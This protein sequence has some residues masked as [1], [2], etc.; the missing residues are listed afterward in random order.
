MNQKEIGIREVPN[1]GKWLT[2]SF[3]HLFAMFGATI[4]VPFLVGLSPAVALVSSGLGTLAYLLIT[5][6]QIPAYLGSSFAFIAPIVLAKSLGGME[7]VMVGSFLAG[8]VYGGVALMIRGLG[9]KWLLQIL[10]PIVVGVI[11]VI[12]LG[13][14][15]T[16]VDMAMY[17]PG[18]DPKVYSLPHFSAALVTLGITIIAAVFLKGFFSLIPVLVG[19]V[20]GYVYSYFIGLID[21]T[22]VREA[23]WFQVPDLMVPFVTYTP[24]FSWQIALIMVPIAVVTITEHIGDQMVLSKVA[25]KNFIAKPGLHRSIMGDGVATMIASFLGECLIQRTEKISESLR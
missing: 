24:V 15:T 6:G 13:L 11:I 5:K 7:A 18:S 17:I 14:A 23:Q 21:F 3:Q 16:A 12:G 4:L 19:I 1:P 22:P 10:P 8:L 25:G 20:G 9:I 2:L